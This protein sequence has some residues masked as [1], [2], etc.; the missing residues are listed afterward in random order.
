MWGEVGIFRTNCTALCNKGWNFFFFFFLD[1]YF[2]NKHKKR[3]P[4]AQEA[5][6]L[7][8]SSWLQLTTMGNC[9]MYENASKCIVSSKSME[10]FMVL[11]TQAQKISIATLCGLFGTLCIFENCLVLYLIF[12]SPGMRRKPSYIFISSL[13]LADLL[14]SII[15][16]TSFVNFHVFNETDPS[17]ELFLLKLGGVNTSFTASLSSLL[18]M[19]LDRYISISRPSKY[20][21]L[22]TRKRAWMVLGVLWVMCVATASLPLLGW[23][24]CTL[25][26]VCSELFPFV[27][28]N[29]LS[30]WIC[31]VMVLLGCI[32]CIYTHVLWRAHQHVAYMGKH[33]EQVGKQ[34]ARMRM[35]IMLAKTLVMV[36]TVLV[37]CWLP[38]LILMIYSIFVNLNNHLRK[39]FAFCST[40][41]LLNSM[42]NPIIYALR[43]KELY[44]SLRMLLSRCRR[45]LSTSNDIPEAESVHRPSMIETVCED[46]RVM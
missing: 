4:G 29:Y 30:S 14:A 35:D 42:V 40:L 10:C 9:E 45:Q 38:A 3:A 15:F 8:A 18:L 19:A 36:L 39:V 33:Q 5:K 12:S 7:P 27:D 11:S 20:K 21:L 25:N 24:C 16:V 37:L 26:S 22:V 1:E 28:N 31:L 6:T 44:S 46:V 41:Y 13:A 2:L 32:V 43:S 17:K 23:N 34:N